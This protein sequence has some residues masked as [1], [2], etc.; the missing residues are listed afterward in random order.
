[1]S[2]NAPRYAIYYAPSTD[3]ALWQFG[4]EVLGYD[5]ATGENIAPPDFL[6]DYIDR[7]PAMTSEPRKYGFHATLKAPFNL[8]AGFDEAM[9]IFAVQHFAGMTTKVLCGGLRVASVGPFLALIPDGDESAL[10]KLAFAI[11]EH[12][13]PFRAA[14]SDED[15]TR[16]LASPL[17][18][19]QIQYLNRFG[20]P[21]VND[22]FRFHMTLTNSLHQ[23]DRQTVLAML[24]RESAAALSQFNG[25]VD[26]ICLFKQDTAAAR[27]KIIASADLN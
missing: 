17:T 18:S 27:F 2:T 16:R 11:V 3:S 15:R 21:Y 8:A 4:S 1:M 25:F 13:E 20:Y 9:L 19:K 22:E 14:I 7:W 5:A 23:D 26:R 12:F 24:E 6:E 10:N